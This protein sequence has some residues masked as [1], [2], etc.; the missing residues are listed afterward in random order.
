MQRAALGFRV[1]SGWAALVAVAGSPPAVVGP[2]HEAV[3]CGVLLGSG[4]PLPPLAQ[5]LASRAKVCG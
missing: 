3:G 5:I 4:R 2:G 1:H